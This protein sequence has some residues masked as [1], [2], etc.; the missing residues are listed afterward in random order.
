MKT[1]FGFIEVLGGLLVV[2]VFLLVA[3]TILAPLGRQW[4]SV[5][6]FL[7]FA[8]TAAIISSIN[9]K[10]NGKKENRKSVDGVR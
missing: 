2:M 10:L 5:S 4:S 3:V 9:L 7:F 8:V 6:I 1:R